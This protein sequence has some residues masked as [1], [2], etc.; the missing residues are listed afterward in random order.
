MAIRTALVRR[1]VARSEEGAAAYS[2]VL[3]ISVAVGGL[4]TLFESVHAFPLLVAVAT[5][6]LAVTLVAG[7][8]PAQP[9]A[10]ALLWATIL[11]GTQGMALVPPLMM[12]VLCL[13]LALG[14]D[15]LLE[16]I[17]D[18][19]GGRSAAEPPSGWIEER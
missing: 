8:E 18:D 7:A 3:L 19:W 12:I 4:L 15:R 5:L 17:R 9:W 10:A 16:W 6:A 13:A 1:H 11:V 14:P 2:A